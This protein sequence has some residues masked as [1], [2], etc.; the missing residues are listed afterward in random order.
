M[1]MTHTVEPADGP[2]SSAS[3]PPQQGARTG[4]RPARGVGT[5]TRGKEGAGA[6]P[7]S[8]TTPTTSPPGTTP[9]RGLPTMWPPVLGV[10]D[11][12]GSDVEVEVDGDALAGEDGAASAPSEASGERVVGPS[13]PLDAPLESTIDL[14]EDGEEEH[15]EVDPVLVDQGRV[16][17]DDD[18]EDDVDEDDVSHMQVSGTTSLAPAIQPVGFAMVL[19]TLSR[20]LERLVDDRRCLVS[21][22]LLRRLRGRLHAVTSLTGQMLEALLVTFEPFPDTRLEDSAAD[23]SWASYW[24]DVVATHLPE[25][26]DAPH[27]VVDSAQSEATCPV[28]ANSAQLVTTRIAD[29]TDETEA[30]AE[31]GCVPGAQ[32]AA[33]PVAMVAGTALPSASAGV[34]LVG[35][36][37][38]ASHGGPASFAVELVVRPGGSAGSGLVAGTSG[39]PTASV[40]PP[41]SES[42]A[43]AGTGPGST[44]EVSL[45]R[46]GAGAVQPAL[47]QGGVTEGVTEGPAVKKPCLTP[48]LPPESASELKVT[49]RVEW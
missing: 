13:V 31:C 6:R 43:A 26:E 33:H 21:G 24:W 30:A 48:T 17:A 2:A 25:A 27:T 8:S 5:R 40:S 47:T 46:G 7:T 10:V 23:V 22:L 3:R 42:V 38:V 11:G 39:S 15:R 29:V 12:S 14:L 18:T 49:V 16:E 44:M 4:S 32:N 19:D 36:P 34:A 37:V 41:P 1:L 28:V 20:A 35:A 45:V 9:L